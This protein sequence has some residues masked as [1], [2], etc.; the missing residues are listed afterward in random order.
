MAMVGA[1]LQL[2]TKFPHHQIYLRAYKMDQ[3]GHKLPAYINFHKS[4]DEFI[5][6]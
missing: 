3:K 5:T 4:P 2:A 1:G 6:A